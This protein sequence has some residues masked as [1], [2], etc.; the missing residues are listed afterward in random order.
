[1]TV[2][3]ANQKIY[4]RSEIKEL[5]KSLRIM[6]AKAWI[7][8]LQEAAYKKFGE[9]IDPYHLGEIVE[10]HLHMEFRLDKSGEEVQWVKQSNRFEI[11]KVFDN[12]SDGEWS[13]LFGPEP[14]NLKSCFL[15]FEDH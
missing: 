6:R 1:M 7:I 9:K 8:S 10:R 11:E 5:H 14:L 13:Y 4:V 12:I 3:A 15:S 2:T